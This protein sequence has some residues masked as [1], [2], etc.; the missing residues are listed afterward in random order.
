MAASSFFLPRSFSISA[1]PDSTARSARVLG[2]G[3]EAGEDL[4]AGLLEQIS[5]E[6]ALDLS[7]EQSHKG[8]GTAITHLATGDDA[9]GLTAGQFILGLGQAAVIHQQLQHQI[10]AGLGPLREAP[11]VVIGGAFYQTDQQ[12]DLIDIQ[13]VDRN[14]EV[15]VGG[16]AETVDPLRE[17]LP[18]IDLVEVGL[19]DL[20]L[21]VAIVDQHSHIGFLQFSP[22]AALTGQEEV[23]GQLLGEGTAPLH[24]ATSDQ[25]GK[26]GAH[27]GHRRDAAMLVEV[28][29]F[30]GEQGH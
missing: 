27:D 28:A 23:F 2:D 12:G 11:W 22:Q 19:E 4:E 24:G 3:V 6:A 20:V 16:E 7:L 9:E 15:E 10:T 14:A 25:V 18:Q 29:I 1:R 17:V 21:A 13:L 5:A 8:R 26:H 30:G